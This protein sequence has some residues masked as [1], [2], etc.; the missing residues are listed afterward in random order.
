MIGF[1][2]KRKFADTEFPSIAQIEAYWNTL[3]DP[4]ALPPRHA[5][6][7]GEIA[8]SLP[9]AF[10]LEHVAEQNTRFRVAGSKVTNVLGMDLRGMPIT[11]LIAPDDRP[12]FSEIVEDMFRMPATARVH[13]HWSKA[14]TSAPI[15]QLLLLPLTDQNG[16]CA[17]AIGCLEY[18]GRKPKFPNRFYLSGSVVRQIPMN[19][20]P[21]KPMP[22][23]SPVIT[24]ALHL[25]ASN[26]QPQTATPATQDAAQNPPKLRVVK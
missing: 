19:D 11:S 3:K 1:Y 5:I 16:K 24:P 14:E 8:K 22:D 20:R 7:P 25:V 26:E 4:Q 10:I 13:L 6:D 2:R 9:N 12:L 15:G 18:K 21:R 23:L 17:R